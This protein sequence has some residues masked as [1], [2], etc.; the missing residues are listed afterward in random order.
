MPS[1]GPR[2]RSPKPGSLSAEG[3]VLVCTQLLFLEDEGLVVKARQ[4]LALGGYGDQFNSKYGAVIEDILKYIEEELGLS[5]LYDVRQEE[6]E[7]VLATPHYPEGRPWPAK[8]ADVINHIIDLL[9]ADAE[10]LKEARLV[11]PVMCLD[12]P[13][14]QLIRFVLRS[15]PDVIGPRVRRP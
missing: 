11:T 9:N 10:V 1:P 8:P 4:E 12:E 7:D 13:I 15:Q 3:V 14:G 2:R 6:R 5:L